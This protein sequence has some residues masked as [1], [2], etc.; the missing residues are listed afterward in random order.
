MM[1]G[2]DPVTLTVREASAGLERGDFS[3]AELCRAFLDRAAL[4]EPKVRALLSLDPEDVLRQA[5]E[6]DARR[7]AGRALGPLDG[8]PVTLKDN[9]AVKDAPCTCASKI[10]KGFV[11]PYDSFVARRLKNAGCVLLG[12]ANMDEFAMGS[13]CENSAFQKTANPW[14]LDRVPGGSSGGSAAAVAS[15]ITCA[16]LGSDTGGSIRQ[17]A[18]FCGVVGLKP[19]YGRVSRNGLVAFASS[20][21]QIGPMTKS[22]YDAAL[23]FDLIAGHDDGDT[24]SLPGDSGGCAADLA[25]FEGKGADLKGVRIGLPK[26][27]FELDGISGEVRDVC[28]QAKETLRSLGAEF[29]EVSLPHTKYAMACYYIIATAEASSN[30]A[31][32]DGIRYGYRSAEAADINSVYFRSRGEGFG[33]EVKRRI[34]LGTYVLSSGYYDAYY[35]RAQK[36]RTLLRRDFEKA[37]ESCDVIF[38]PVSPVT[39]FRFGEKA[40][41]LQMYLSD[42]FTI[43]LNLSGDCGISVPAGIA[44]GSGMPSGIQ[45]MAPAL[46]EKRLFRAARA[47]ECA[48]PQKEFRASL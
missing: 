10:L 12:R 3:S 43:A 48:R 4:T 24:T 37:Y 7:K 28:E 27:Y 14:G 42:I 13:S 41:P 17:P 33:P 5:A 47:F 45:F 32:F 2:S 6:S 31:R 19:T 9:I 39:A 8:V 46:Q 26:E 15:G 40:D 38:T 25:A 16:A 36:V 29:T 35:L 20:L 1:N 30:L 34:M 21:D 11:S 23:L 18:S 44:A 22:V